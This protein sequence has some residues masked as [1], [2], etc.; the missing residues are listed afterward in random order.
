MRQRH[1]VRPAL[2]LSCLVLAASPA[3]A[4]LRS[5]PPSGD[6]QKAAV[7]QWIGP[8][9]VSISYSS[10]DVHAP[11]GA[12]RRG[13]IWGEL[14]PWGYATDSFG[15]CGSRCP[16]RAGANESTVLRLSSDVEIGGKRLAAGSYGVFMLPGQQ[17]WTLILSRDSTSWGHYTYTEAED[18]LR[19]PVKPEK[20]PY[21]EWLTYEF[22][23]RRPDRATVALMWEDLAVPFTIVV[24]DV[25]EIYATRIR[26]E[27]RNFNGF[28]ADTWRQ[29]AEFFLEAK[30]HPE[31]AL[32]IAQSA[33]SKP[34]TGEKT[35]QNMQ[36]LAR[37]Q[38]ANGRTSEAAATM[39]E[40]MTLPTT[41][42]TD[43]H[44][45]GR[46]L[47]GEGKNAEALKVF[48]ANAKRFPNQ[49]PVNVGLARGYAGVGRTAEALAAAR[50]ALAQAP[51]DLNRENLRRMIAD[52]EQK[53]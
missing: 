1:R 36:V 15:T 9:E 42:P 32:A 39:A 35:F 13:K 29:A 30:I 41:T 17:E 28:D 53:K 49:W 47:Q 8:V 52:L 51:D 26:Q 46:R 43:I 40:A 37:A 11:D 24:P 50:A 2:A 25:N 48:E 3:A 45:Y 19:V 7:T 23:D 16:W 21:H 14:V 10:P 33:V 6:N 27:L 38:A 4:Q 12:D 31:E 34:F 18:A 5:G 20:N 22:T 44:M